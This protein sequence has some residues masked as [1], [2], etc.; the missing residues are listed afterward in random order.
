MK[1]RNF[2]GICT[3]RWLL[4]LSLLAVG[5]LIYLLYRQQ[6]IMLFRITDFM[7]LS[8]YINDARESASHLVLPPFFINSLPAGIWTASYLVMMYATTI[9]LNRKFRLMIS[10]PLPLSFIVLEFMQLYG[11]CPGT[12][13][14]YDLIC[15][16]IP[17]IIFI[18]SI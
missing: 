1:I 18:K 13:D 5:G 4:S 11:W 8:Q 12:F 15:Y 3:Q 2:K 10:L 7:G 17:L 6:T 9:S 14:I 16:I